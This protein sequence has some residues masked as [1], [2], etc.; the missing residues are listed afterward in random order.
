MSE[1][2]N[3]E[4][5]GFFAEFFDVLQPDAP[6][7]AAFLDVARN[8][9]G[10]LLELGCGTGRLLLP[11]VRGGIETDGID[12]A[13][14]MIARCREKLAAEPEEVRARARL[15]EADL[16]DFETGRDYGV[17]LVSN[18]VVNHLRTPADLLRC[19][20]RVREH[21]RRGGVFVVDNAAPD[22]REMI[23]ASGEME[24]LEFV[25][26]ERGTQLVSRFTPTY[27]FL[28]QVE[29]D[30]IDLTEYDG[31]T[32]VRQATTRVVSRWFHPP[33]IRLALAAAGFR[34][35]EER[36]S[37][38]GGPLREGCPEVVLLATQA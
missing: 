30:E 24:T 6:E 10:P 38:R 9:D 35:L 25:H 32:V 11:L 15:I 14:D 12:N 22:L 19:F 2:A 36:G 26:P 27:D 17:V 37:V 13:P 21:L 34:I 7:A 16:L 20:G 8:A 31:G 28:E 1:T 23:A 4:Y 3:S 5:E 33:E 29:T 18:N